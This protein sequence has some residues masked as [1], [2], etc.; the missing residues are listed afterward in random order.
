MGL[1]LIHAIAF[2]TPALGGYPFLGLSPAENPGVSLALGEVWV[3][4]LLALRAGDIINLE[5][6]PVYGL[7]TFPSFH[8]TVAILVVAIR[9]QGAWEAWATPSRRNTPSFPARAAVAALDRPSAPL[10]Q[11]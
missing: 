3:P 8:T 10:S 4:H 5:S 11:R 6:G 2:F 9:L 7:I 1:V